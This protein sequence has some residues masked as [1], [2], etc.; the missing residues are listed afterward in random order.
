M[1]TAQIRIPEAEIAEFCRRNGIRRLSFFGSVL[2]D[3]FSDAS[4]VDILVEFE[5]DRRV[6]YLGLAAME[7]EL[8]EVVGRKVDL[9]TPDELSRYFRDDVLRA[10]QVQYVRECVTAP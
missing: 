1:A 6:G 3:R 5:P 2:T 10:A 8:S 7:R 4:D 9:R